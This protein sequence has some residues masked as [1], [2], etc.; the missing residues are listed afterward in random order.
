M[1]DVPVT[2]DARFEIAAVLE[3]ADPHDAFVSVDHARFAELPAGARV[4]TSSLRRQCQ[5]KYLRP[6]LEVMPL[7]GNVET[8][9]RKLDE[10]QCDAVILAMAG[11]ERLGLAARVRERLPEDVCLPAIGQGAIGI[12]CRSADATLRERLRLLEHAPTRRCVDAERAL[13][14]G[15]GGSCVAPIAGYG[16]IVGDALSLT[17]L[18]GDPQGMR[19][20]RGHC[21]GRIDDA[22]ALGF[23]L[24]AQL[25]RQGARALL[26][27]GA[28]S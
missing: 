20:L 15:L 23:E 17:G 27:S 6:D 9:L 24:A 5:I 8:R 25:E 21:T 3:R 18:V 19:I 16:R 12:E 22:R 26:A 7:R 14:E 1:K 11:L 10:G 2:L 4:G 28:Q 13:N